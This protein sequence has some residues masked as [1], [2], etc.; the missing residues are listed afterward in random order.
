M[1]CLL[2]K[3]SRHP[4]LPQ[5]QGDALYGAQVFGDI[6]A[7]VAVAPGGADGQHAVAVLEADGEAVDLRL[8]VEAT[9]MLRRDDP[10]AN[11]AVPFE[12]AVLRF[13]EVLAPV[14]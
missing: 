8:S 12:T 5:P 14:F 3:A 13:P 9:Q 4:R 7:H 6:L 2:E 1:P 11:T 10:F